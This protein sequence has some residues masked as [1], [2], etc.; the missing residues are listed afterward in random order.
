MAAL[1]LAV[2]LGSTASAITTTTVSSGQSNDINAQWTFPDTV[3]C[4]AGTFPV[5]TFI[6]IGSTQQTIKSG[7]TTTTTNRVD[8]FVGNFTPCGSFFEFKSFFDTGTATNAGLNTAS[9]SG[10][11][12]FD[13][14]YFVDLNLTFSG[15]DS[16]TQG[17]TMNRTRF[18]GFMMLTRN[19]GSSRTASIG[20]SINANG[21]VVSAS[22]FIDPDAMLF[23]NKSGQK[24]IM[25]LN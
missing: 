2:P 4:T 21:N 22:S 23:I 3:T 12:V 1:A 7:G 6:S 19:N 18:P 13:D 9:L 25:R 8:L 17:N 10:H 5:D 24:T 14:G 15:T 11:F 20:G 16:I